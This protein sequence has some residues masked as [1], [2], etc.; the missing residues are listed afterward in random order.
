MNKEL[1]CYSLFCS[2]TCQSEEELK[3]HEQEHNLTNH[4]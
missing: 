3:K 2:F 1:I 4:E